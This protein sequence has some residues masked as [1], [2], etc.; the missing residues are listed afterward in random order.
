LLVA[1]R[2]GKRHADV[3]RAIEDLNENISKL[4]ENEH[5]RNFA[6]MQQH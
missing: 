2:F 3:L 4:V 1:Q 6:L 5:Q